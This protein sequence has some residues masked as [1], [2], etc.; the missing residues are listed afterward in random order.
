MQ[1][2]GENFQKII[3][4]EQLE[5]LV[6]GG[7]FNLPS[8]N[9]EN[10]DI[11]SLP[12]YGRDVNQMVLELWMTYSCNKMWKSQL[13]GETFL[14]WY[15][16]PALSWS[17][18]FT[19]IQ[20]SATKIRLL[21]RSHSGIGLARRN[22][23]QFF[24]YDKADQGILA[25]KTATLKDEILTKGS[26]HDANSNWQIF[27]QY[28]QKIMENCI[29]Q[30]M[31]KGRY[32]LSWLGHSLRKKIRRKKNQVPLSGKTC[33]ATKT[34]ATLACLSAIASHSKK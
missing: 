10:N 2:L 4:K 19:L 12:Q 20:E 18:Q 21:R 9:W 11:S 7:G 16:C 6:L 15:L 26:E 27:T 14:T 17:I 29:P 25:F 5:N 22:H 13:E 24:M 33:E 31:I 3:S 8:I 32:N 23:K 34:S 30:K 28:L 1:A